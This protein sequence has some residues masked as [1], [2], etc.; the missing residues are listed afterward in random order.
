MITASIVLIYTIL[1]GFLA[2]SLTDV[3]QAI[4]M[5]VVLVGLPLL[6]IMGL[7]GWSEVRDILATLP[8]IDKAG[9]PIMEGGGSLLNPVSYAL[10]GAVGAVGI[11]LGSP[12]SPHILVRYMSIKDPKQ[13]RW[14]AYVGTSWNLVMAAGA[15]FIGLVGRAWFNTLDQL[16]GA[17]PENVYIHLANQVLHPF[18]VGLM[19]A[20]IAG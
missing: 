20:S 1:G 19:L 13:F 11:G 2:V 7:G 3:M 12:G 15:L 6:G 4:F 5:I 8:Q 17:D 16:P 18:W 14:T 10:I 9:T